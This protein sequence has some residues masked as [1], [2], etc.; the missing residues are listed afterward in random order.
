MAPVAAAVTSKTATAGYMSGLRALIT[1]VVFALST[2]VSMASKAHILCL[3][4]A[5]GC[6]N[7]PRTL[8]I[9]MQVN[10]LDFLIGGVN[11]CVVKGALD[12]AWVKWFSTK[13]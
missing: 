8:G 1:V 7:D 9:F 12:S 11:A 10:W 3:D 13:T 5:T 6:H 4:P 2:G